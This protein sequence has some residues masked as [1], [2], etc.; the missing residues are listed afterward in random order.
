MAEEML[1]E[2]IDKLISSIVFEQHFELKSAEASGPK[3]IKK[4]PCCLCSSCKKMIPISKFANH[5]ESCLGMFN[6]RSVR[7]SKKISN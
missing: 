3:I 1:N 6:R 4:H 2:M 7:K 5:L